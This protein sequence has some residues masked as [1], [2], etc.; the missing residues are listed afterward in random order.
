MFTATLTVA[1]SRLHSFEAT[2]YV[3][4]HAGQTV[5][6]TW[7]SNDRARTYPTHVAFCKAMQVKTTAYM[8]YAVAFCATLL[9]LPRTI[10]KLSDTVQTLC[11]VTRSVDGR[12]CPRYVQ[13]HIR[14]D[15]VGGLRGTRD[16]GGGNDLHGTLA[17]GS[18]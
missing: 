7:V 10:A 11:T 16:Y 3:I 4:Y 15:S 5:Q 1:L 14:S 2:Y 18:A 8:R 12:T 13:G 6:A 9:D 17:A